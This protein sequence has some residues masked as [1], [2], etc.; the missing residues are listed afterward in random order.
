M[1]QTILES[2]AGVRHNTGKRA[3]HRDE[4]PHIAE[5]PLPGD[6][7]V[8]FAVSKKILEQ[9]LTGLLFFYAMY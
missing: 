7:G 1:R 6:T 3:I 9:T 4:T 5:Y 2:I 8:L